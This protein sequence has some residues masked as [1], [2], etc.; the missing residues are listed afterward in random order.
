MEQRTLPLNQAPPEGESG[1][2]NGGLAG[3]FEPG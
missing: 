1:S 3:S 2:M